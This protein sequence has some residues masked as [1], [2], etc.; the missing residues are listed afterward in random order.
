MIAS[1]GNSAAVSRISGNLPA[2]AVRRTDNNV[3]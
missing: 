1:S 2:Q 3:V